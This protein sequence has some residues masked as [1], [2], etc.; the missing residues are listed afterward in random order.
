M[1][2]NRK[3][4]MYAILREV[5][6]SNDKIKYNAETFGVDK[7]VFDEVMLILNEEDFVKGISVMNYDNTV[8]V[9][10][11]DKLRITLSGINF[12]EENNPY[13]KTYKGLKELREWL[14]F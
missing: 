1:E 8:N 14:P 12:L 9:M 4:L 10:V 7:K 3:K 2:I 6:N 13:A 5:N 11:F